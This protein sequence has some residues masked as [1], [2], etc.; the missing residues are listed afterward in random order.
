MQFNR[1][2][3]FSAA[4]LVT[5]VAVLSTVIDNGVALPSTAITQPGTLVAQSRPTALASGTFVAAEQPTTGSARIVLGDD[6]T[7]YLELGD[8]FSTSS[9]GPDL[10]VLLS[11]SATPP[12][13]YS[14]QQSG[15]YINLGG[16]RQP[17]GAQRYPIPDAVNLSN[18]QS[19]VIWCRMA[20]ATFGYA[21]IRVSAT[22]STTPAPVRGLW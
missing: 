12:A 4:G 18:F 13:S 9:Q 19:V 21:P 11:P 2:I 6:G 7:R 20:N 1:L 15:Q 3:R 17:T 22:A 5:M 10:H 14:E 16:L 8:N